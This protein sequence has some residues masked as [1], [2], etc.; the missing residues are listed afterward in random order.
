MI[1]AIYYKHPPV[2]TTTTYIVERCRHEDGTHVVLEQPLFYPE[3]GGQPSDQGTIAGIPVESVYLKDNKIFHVLGKEPSADNVHCQV[4]GEVRWHHMQHHSGQ[5]LLS[6]VC[7]DMY[8]L[9]TVGFHLGERYATIDLEG[10]DIDGSW[11][12]VVED[13][14]N[15]YIQEDRALTT[16][17]ISRDDL[18][19]YPRR[20]DVPLTGAIRLVS[21][22]GIDSAPC[23]GT[24]VTSTGQIGLLKVTKTEKVRSCTRVYFICGMRAVNDY[25]N[26]QRILR[27]LADMYS[28]GETDLLQRVQADGQRLKELEQNCRGLKQELAVLQASSLAAGHWF[29]ETTVAEREDMQLWAAALL[30]EGVRV[31]VVRCGQRLLIQH[32]GDLDWHCGQFITSAAARFGG[33]GGGSSTAGQVY[34]ADQEQQASF[35]D[36]LRSVLEAI[37]HG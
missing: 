17:T 10:P 16:R 25:Q 32:S 8:G 27:E 21:I 34:F 31:A 15:R 33:R 36:H 12:P 22:A 18:E 13:A 1:E 35:V 2:L 6:A 30:S 4:N 29:V 19:H 7:Q 24:H 3:G 9:V 23:C 14:V 28:T 5:H 37:N 26:K 11:I 20:G